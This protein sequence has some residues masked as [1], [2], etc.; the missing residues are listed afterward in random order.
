MDTKRLLLC[1]AMACT[2]AFPGCGGG[3]GSTGPCI[4]TA[5]FGCLSSS[6][7]SQ[8][9]EETLE[10]NR[11]I[12]G[13]STD[14]SNQ[15]GLA[16]INADRAY[17]HLELAKG[18]NVE[19]GEGVTVGLIDTGIDPEHAVFAGKTISEEFLGDAVDERGEK[20]SHGTAVASVIGANPE[21]LHP[22]VREHGFYGVAWGAG[23]KMF[24]IPLG[25]APPPG[26]LYKP[27]TLST[28]G[29]IDSE[30]A[31]HYQHVLGQG[32]DVLNLSF[33]V[34]GVIENYA[35]QDIRS[36]YGRTI[37]ALAQ[38][39]AQDKTVLVWAAGNSHGFTCTPGTDNCDG[40]DQIDNQGNPAGF[41]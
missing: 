33:G 8:K 15:W 32:L 25:E 38:T 19:P 2:A 13:D 10:M 1:F 35:E 12:Y 16:A 37:A 5:D 29:S 40:S 34:Y 24:A 7:Y 11:N 28:L 6:S 4:R 31:M 14:F 30:D 17:A 9:L 22:D 39:D 18:G 20:F 26:T 27:T 3:G 41:P 36:Y 23:L 21:N